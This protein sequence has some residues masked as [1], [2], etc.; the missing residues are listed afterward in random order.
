MF[1]NTAPFFAVAA[2]VMAAIPFLNAQ[3]VRATLGGRVTDAQGATVPNALVTVTSQETNVE[4]HTRTNPQGNWTMQFLLP[5][6]Y[7]FT[8]SEQG[9][10]TARSGQIELQAADIK[11]I[12]THLELGS[13]RD[14]VAVTAE[15]P[16]IDT[17]S[18]TS[19]TVISQEQ[20][21]EIPSMTHI[22]TLLA[23]LSPGVIAQDQNNN[24][25]HLWS[26]NAASQFTA[27]GGRNNVYSNMFLLDGFP[28][29]KSGGDIAFNPSP[30]TVAE[31]RVQ[32][33]AY[34]ASIGRQAGSTINQQSKSGRKNF[35]GELYEFNQNSAMNANLF[36]TNL[37]GGAVT[38]VHFNEYGGMFGGPV[39]LP[40]LYDGRKKTFFFV[41]FDDTR[42]INP[43]GTAPISV[44]TALERTG[45]FSQSF[46]TQTVNGQLQ[47]YPIQVYDPQTVNAK[48]DRQ[49]FPG[50]AIP[51]TRL[52][53][54]SQNILGYVPPPNSVSDPTGNAVNNYVPPAVRTDEYPL[55]TIRADQ[56]W[57][58]N[59]R[60]FATIHWASL[61]ETSGDNFGPGNI[62]S[63]GYTT[64]V[65]KSLGLD[66][67]WIL[68]QNRV[69]DLRFGIT[70]YEEGSHDAGAGFDPTKLGF[71]ADFS[72]KLSVPSFPHITGI[73][74]D[75]G[76]NQ[77]NSFTNTTYYSWL[78]NLTHIHGNHTFRY[79]AEY[80]ILQQ[81]GGSVGAQPDFDF[82]NSNWTRPNNN[83]AGGTGQGSSFASFLLG[84]PNG[85]NVPMNAQSFYSQHYMGFYF[86]DDW[87]VTS[88][89]TVNLGLRWDFERPV[90]ERYDRL[91][92]RFD[93]TAINP[94]SGA[95][96]AAYAA[97][98]ANSANASNSGVQL[99]KQ[100]APAANFQVP[101]A[102]LFAGVNG[103]PRTPVNADYGQWQ[104]RI[105]FAYRLTP[106]TVLRGGVGR[107]SQ[108]SYITGGQNGFSRTTS[109]IATQDNYLTPYDTLSNP[110][111]G[112]ILQP[113]GSALGPLTNLGSAPSWDDPNLG[114]FNS[115]EYSVHLQHQAGRWLFEVGYSHNK[116][117]DIAWGWNQN[118]PSFQ[119]WQ[120]LQAP[121]F[122]AT[123]RP[124]DTLPWNVQVPN[125]F[126]QLPGVTGGSIGSSK[127]V[128]LN[129]LLNPIP[130]LGTV[131]QNRPTGSNQ[132]DAGLGKIEHRFANHFSVL[133]SFTWSKLFEDS[134]F[135]GDQIT[136]ARI[137]HKL[138]GEDRPLH[139]SIAPIYD[140]PFGHG[141]KFGNSVSRWTDLLI[142]GWQVVGTYSI[143][144]GVPVVF[145]TNSFFTGNDVAL[146]H[147]KQ[148]LNEWF[149]T[150][151]FV[152]FP[153][154]TT[155]I[156][157]YPAWTGVQNL[158]GAN[159]KP[160]AGDSIKNGVYQ[161]F[162]NYVRYYPTRWADVR[163]SHVNSA[164]VGVRKNFALTEHT[165]LQLRIDAFNVFN[166]P[167][168]AAPNT[169]PGSANFG[170]VPL[171][172]QNQSR[173]VELA[174]KLFF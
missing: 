35:S 27:N 11:Q 155:D 10:K 30:D 93:P 15:V 45:D 171:A 49:L 12:D 53:P 92:D 87:R 149:D 140:L 57:N 118:L 48:G 37:I 162:A 32:T 79:G 172:Q 105:G 56:N 72:S 170:R 109:L 128:A 50:N 74:G 167:R 152:A 125:P 80:W 112:G 115:W 97:I 159:Y 33:N 126:Y 47:R 55:L 23:T 160:A 88:K 123:G 46:T 20:I 173:S 16:L 41:A 122:D 116:T 106:N 104:P 148:S 66:H 142:G 85:G 96:Q 39:W 107:F 136:G 102:Q 141:R 100:F 113:T 114:R 103:T 69:L 135:L 71:P 82:N 4:Q 77:A 158:P 26:Y 81:A 7:T 86:Q 65:D 119:L 163:A 42:N 98:L 51:K 63:G 147:D 145:S 83:N 25:G 8:I 13:T 17:T 76:T 68:N 34:D 134:S 154:K 28:N 156:S 78:A 70:R 111:R 150:S 91:T 58:D 169:D 18:A 174:G 14:T 59:H 64:R 62:A 3:E 99:L 73:A 29:I 139:F 75:F 36:Q 101:G 19:G 44:P 133:A 117:Y 120:Q 166:H 24:V 60:S 138:G 1:R 67:V 146:P 54:I 168:F 131:T 121:Q 124:M 157:N 132:Y 21:E 89:L 95:A 52:N 165:H 127:T 110:F 143:Q 151:Q 108:A 40:K 144:S 84:L 9:F 161:D 153:S 31:F 94:I 5:G 164:D 6:I 61:T 130:L 22:S 137:E 90:Q 2:G 43:L 38:P 129:Q